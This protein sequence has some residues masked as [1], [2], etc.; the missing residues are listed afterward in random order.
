M[1]LGLM[2]RSFWSNAQAADQC[3]DTMAFAHLSQPHG[4]QETVLENFHIHWSDF[5]PPG[6]FFQKFWRYDEA[7]TTRQSGL[8]WLQHLS[9]PCFNEAAAE[10]DQ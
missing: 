10:P 7:A 5:L 3:C 9:L 2:R 8:N 4:L 1:L 6:Q